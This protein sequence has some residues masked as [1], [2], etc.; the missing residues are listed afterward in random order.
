MIV[1]LRITLYYPSRH[2]SLLTAKATGCEN[3]DRIHTL[4][5]SINTPIAKY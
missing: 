1:K 4:S 2:R 3:I 5:S